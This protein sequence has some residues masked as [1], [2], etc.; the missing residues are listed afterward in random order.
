MRHGYRNHVVQLRKSLP[1]FLAHQRRLWYLLLLSNCGGNLLL[2]FGD[3]FTII[4]KTRIIAKTSWDMVGWASCCAVF[5]RWRTRRTLEVSFNF[6]FTL[7]FRVLVI[8]MVNCVINEISTWTLPICCF[9]SC[10]YRTKEK[11]N[12]FIM[13]VK[14]HTYILDQLYFQQVVKIV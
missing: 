9:Q 4:V 1:M 11:F 3:N 2:Q 5:I 14:I 7:I 12:A 13:L 10:C 6:Q 8:C